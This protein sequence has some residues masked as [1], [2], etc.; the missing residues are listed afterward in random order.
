MRVSG[1]QL[2]KLSRKAL[3]PG[4]QFYSELER[5]TGLTRAEVVCLAK[6]FQALS[7]ERGSEGEGFWHYVANV[8]NGAV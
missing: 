5:L 6:D 4:S 2:A 1:E 3:H 7:E 8:V